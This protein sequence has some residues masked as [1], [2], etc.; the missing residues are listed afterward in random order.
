MVLLEKRIGNKENPLEIDKLREYLNLRFEKLSV[1]SESSDL[2][3]ANE[4]TQSILRV[5]NATLG[6]VTSLFISG[7]GEIMIIDTVM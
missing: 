1:Q 6:L 4:E 5:N 7:P 3:R 2:S